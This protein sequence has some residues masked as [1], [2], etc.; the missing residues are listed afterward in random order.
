MQVNLDDLINYTDWERQKWHD[1]F[2]HRGDQVLRISAGSHGDGRFANVGQLVRHIF[3]AEKR[4]IERLSG[5]TLTDPAS[6]SCDSVETLFDFGE[7]S[8]KDLKEFLE[9]FSDEKWDVP[10]DYKILTYSLKATPRKIVIH[11]L[12]HEIRHWAQIATLLR[13]NGLPA[14]FHDFLFSPVLG[15]ELRREQDQAS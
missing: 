9:A 5:R 3:S 15:G 12:M 13:L 4:Y 2:I 10:E 7:Q 1:W 14:E 6:V 8:R 11:V